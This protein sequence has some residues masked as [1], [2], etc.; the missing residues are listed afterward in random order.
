M[1]I[2]DLVD[3]YVPAVTDVNGVAELERVLS[4]WVNVSDRPTVGLVETYGGSPV[5]GVRL[6][7]DRFVLNRDTTRTAVRESLATAARAG[8]AV[9]LRWHLTV[10]QNGKVNLVTYL[11]DGARSPGWYAYLKPDADRPRPIS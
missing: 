9:E 2:F 6:G 3:G 5:I 10:N 11:P 8:G 4:H 1:S 7:A